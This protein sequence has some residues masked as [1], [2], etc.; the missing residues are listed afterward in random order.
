MN[1][2]TTNNQSL[3][4]AIRMGVGY[5]SDRT[6]AKYFDTSRSTIWLWSKTGRLPKPIKLS[7]GC[8][9]W[10]NKAIKQFEKEAAS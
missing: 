4:E 8:T 3:V 5:S 7:E 1:N 2:D 10:C 6:L 9:R